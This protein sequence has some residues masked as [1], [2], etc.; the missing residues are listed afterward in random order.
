M[1]C[2]YYGG[3]AVY[4]E[5]ELTLSQREAR[6][7]PIPQHAP[8]VRPVLSKQT[9]ENNIVKPAHSRMLKRWMADDKDKG[10][11]WAVVSTD[12]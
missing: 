10:Q 1:M 9:A 4:S 12:G 2:L 5:I 11:C 3:K 7:E 6:G 8:G